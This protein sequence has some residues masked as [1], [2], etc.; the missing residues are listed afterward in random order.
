M[1]GNLPLNCEAA[2]Y[3][4][5]ITEGIACFLAD[6]VYG[7]RTWALWGRG[8]SMGWMI[9]LTGVTF[10]V[11]CVIL[12]TVLQSGLACTI[13]SRFGTRLLIL[14]IEN[15]AAHTG[16]LWLFLLTCAI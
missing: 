8:R 5:V 3:L 1:G 16:A 15:S 13:S 14:H 12:V 7:L 10:N 9:I 6:I 4:Q 11:G 2:A